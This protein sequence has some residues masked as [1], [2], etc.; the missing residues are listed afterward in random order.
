MSLDNVRSDE[1]DGLPQVADLD[2][3]PFGQA[4]ER[5]SERDDDVL[6]EIKGLDHRDETVR[7]LVGIIAETCDFLTEFRRAIPGERYIRGV[8]AGTAAL[9]L[10]PAVLT[11]LSTKVDKSRY[12]QAT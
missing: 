4:G 6:I 12:R 5:A 7:S 10:I 9:G 3:E 1:I 2:G 8:T 11:T